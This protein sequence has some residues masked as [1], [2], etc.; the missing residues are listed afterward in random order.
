MALGRPSD[1]SK[2]IADEICSRLAMGESLRAICGKDRDDFIPHIGTVL[3]WVS[4][5]PDFREQYTRAREVQAETMADEI[6]SI[7]DGGE[8]AK[9]ADPDALA[10]M[11][12]RD[13][14]RVDARKWVA[15]KLLPKKYG[16]KVEVEHSG[17]IQTASDDQ[18]DDKI[19]ALMAK[20]G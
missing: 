12:Q 17:S 14:L 8:G 10:Q 6:V 3:R 19:K 1:Y 4:E 7:A 20:V 15:S 18:L 2:E 16:D 13:R 11:T 9:F 5:R